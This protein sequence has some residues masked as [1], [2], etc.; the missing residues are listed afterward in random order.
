MGL[1]G[2][3]TTF[4]SENSNFLKYVSLLFATTL[5]LLLYLGGIII[6]ILQLLLYRIFAVAVS[7]KQTIDGICSIL[8]GCLSTSCLIGMPSGEIEEA[9]THLHLQKMSLYWYADRQAP[10]R[11]L[12]F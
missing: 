6:N 7:G 11:P 9:A 8:F 12:I 4:R 10:V 2:E 3:V 5:L 1:Q